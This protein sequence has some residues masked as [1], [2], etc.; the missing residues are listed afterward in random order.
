LKGALRGSS[1]I[2]SCSAAE[3]WSTGEKGTVFKKDVRTACSRLVHLHRTVTRDADTAQ[4]MAEATVVAR[5][6]DHLVP[7][8]KAYIDM[9]K[10]FGYKDFVLACEEWVR[11]QPGDV[12]CFKQQRAQTQTPVRGLGNSH[13]HGSQ[14]STRQRPTCFSCGKVGHLARECRSRPPGVEAVTAPVQLLQHTQGAPVRQ[15]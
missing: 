5:A 9:G 12:S 3:D 2:S 10:R 15:K 4:E 7:E 14:T 11:S 8:L 1:E 6:R 13:S